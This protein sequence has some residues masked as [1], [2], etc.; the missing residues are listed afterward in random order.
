MCGSCQSSRLHYV[1]PGSRSF[2]RTSPGSRS[3]RK[4]IETK[5]SAGSTKAQ[6]LGSSPLQ[7]IHLCLQKSP[8][9]LNRIQIRAIRRPFHYIDTSCQKPISYD[10]CRMNR[11]VVLHE[12]TSK[13]KDRKQVSVK[14]CLIYSCSYPS[15]WSQRIA[16]HRNKL[17]PYSMTESCPKHLALLFAAT[18]LLNK[19]RC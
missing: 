19:I 15:F 3:F 16:F 6:D 13:T 14:D 18:S 10:M 8:Q 17:C 1:P 5:V 4:I 11:S 9:I 2:R 7:Y 12:N